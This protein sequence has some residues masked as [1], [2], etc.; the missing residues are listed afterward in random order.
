MQWGQ[1]KTLF[2][3][4]FLI[5]DV[6]L[7]MQFMDSRESELGLLPRDSTNEE[8]LRLNV[9]GLDDLL[10]EVRRAPLI[11]ASRNNFSEEDLSTLDAIPNQEK[12]I[13]NENIIF[14]KL[15]TPVEINLADVDKGAPVE[16][17][18]GKLL[19]S[20][21]YTFWE[22]DEDTNIVILF[23][24]MGLPIYFNKNG[25]VL[26]QLNDDDEM[27]SYIQTEMVEKNK[28]E[29]KVLGKAIDAVSTLY[30]NQGIIKSGDTVLDNELGYHNL[31]TSSDGEQ[32]LNPTWRIKV[33]NG[34]EEEQ[35]Y[36]VNGIEGHYYPRE[37]NSFLEETI[38]EFLEVVKLTTTDNIEL[39]SVS[40]E[41]IDKAELIDEMIAQL[42]TTI[43][44]N[45]VEK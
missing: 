39:L 16:S 34:N 21:N 2:I 32:V 5:L 7:I 44:N 10:D 14:S 42:T 29:E 35:N 45:G 17:L 20:G 1:I 3:I 8:Y 36:F 11:T 4:C 37:W 22:K 15:I 31:V 13:I 30:H 18:Q 38:T 24:N 43:G 23:Q 41:E 28:S 27:V 6:F 9:N 12:I 26:I 25:V 33:E 19:N 40:E